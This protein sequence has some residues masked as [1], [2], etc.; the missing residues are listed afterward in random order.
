MSPRPN[1]YWGVIPA[2]GN[3]YPKICQV[4]KN[5]NKIMRTSIVGEGISINYWDIQPQLRVEYKGVVY[6]TETEA[7]EAALKQ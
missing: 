4:N 5:D 3:N 6:N 2:Q 7:I 1:K